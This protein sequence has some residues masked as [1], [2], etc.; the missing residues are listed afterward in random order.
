MLNRPPEK[1][2]EGDATHSKKRTPEPVGTHGTYM[3]TTRK[4]PV[5]KDKEDRFRKWLDQWYDETVDVS[6]ITRIKRN[7]NYQNILPLGQ[8]AISLILKEMENKLSTHL[9]VALV[10]VAK[11][12][13]VANE[14]KGN[15]KG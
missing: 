12:N 14:D 4:I 15:V 8:D 1:H 13:P 10:A 5:S 2:G 7:E 9:V 6:S 11:T 3:P